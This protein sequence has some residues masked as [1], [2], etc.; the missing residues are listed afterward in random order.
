MVRDAQHSAP[1]SVRDWAWLIPGAVL[2]A[3]LLAHI[4]APPGVESTCARILELTEAAGEP[5]GPAE[6]DACERRY[7]EL[8]EQ[9]SVLRWARMAW[10]TRKAR[11][12]PD[13]GGC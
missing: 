1:R 8:R 6:R 13:A 4:F 3:M 7:R 10:C 9:V 2:S 12:L 5:A 11:S